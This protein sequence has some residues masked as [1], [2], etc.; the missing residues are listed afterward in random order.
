MK[1]ELISVDDV[2]QLTGASRTSIKNAAHRE[3]I[4]Y[5]CNGKIAGFTGEQAWQLRECIRLKCGNPNFVKK[6]KKK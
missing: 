2:V 3:E 4:G 5:F 1:V 6:G